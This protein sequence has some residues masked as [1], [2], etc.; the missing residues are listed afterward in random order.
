M[1]THEGPSNSF[2]TRN[3]HRRQT[4]AKTEPRR[5]RDPLPGAKDKAD[6]SEKLGWGDG[7]IL[8]LK[9]ITSSDQVSDFLIIRSA[10]Y[11]VGDKCAIA[12]EK[13]DIA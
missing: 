11:A 3:Q 2:G 9:S 4:R 13:H 7:G 5:R 6:L 1:Q 10:H 8:C 12:N